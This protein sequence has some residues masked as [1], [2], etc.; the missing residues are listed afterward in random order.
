MPRPG[1][2]NFCVQYYRQPTPLPAEWEDDLRHVRDLGFTAVQLRPQWAWHEPREGEFRWDDIDRLMDL[3]GELGL[4]VL[5]K[6]FVESAPPW[7]FRNYES[8]RYAQDGRPI[9]PRA[10]GSFY[11]GGWL[12]CFDRPLVRE[13][14]ERFVTAG[15]LRY[16]DRDNLLGWHVWNEPRSRPFEDCACA[17]SNALYRRWLA[18]NF[19]SPESFSARFGTVCTDWEE[20]D[21]PPDSSAYYDTWLWRQYRAWAVSDRI[22]WLAGLVRSLDGSR[23][24]FCHVGF[25]SV[26]QPTLLDTCDDFQTAAHVDVYGT[27]FPHWT[28]D[29]HTFARVDRPSLFSN[30]EYRREMFLYSLQAR[31]MAAVKDYF[32]INEVY[33]NSWNYMAEDFSGEDIRF[34]LV[35]AISEGAKGIV[36]WQFRPER[37]SEESI[38]SGLIAPDGSDTER[39][40]A[41]AVVCAARHRHPEAFSTWTPEKSRV[42]LVFGLSLDMYSE[43]EDAEDLGRAGTVCYRY[44]DSL[45][46]W[47]SLFWQ[48]GLAVDIIPA[49]DLARVKDYDLVTLPY[50]HLCSK[51]QAEVIA[52]YVDGG[53]VLLAE[54]GTAFRDSH[55]TWV[56]PVRPGFGLDRLFGCREMSN[57][58]CLSP[59]RVEALGHRLDATRM[60]ARLDPLEG[61]RDLSD[62]RGFLFEK[63]AGNGRTFYFGFYPGISWRDTGEQRFLALAAD[64]L[65]RCGL[66]ADIQPGKPLVRVRRGTVGENPARPAAFVLNYEDS[67]QPVSV[68]LLEPGRYRCLLTGREIEVPGEFSVGP[69]ETLFLV[70]VDF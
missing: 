39:S 45:K 15:I 49:E 4:K 19:G 5:F 44:K 70:P 47:Y 22:R 10:R 36:I 54:P 3:T 43:I 25:N 53:G 55:T 58:A 32:W 28:G 30:P 51:E 65:K 31:W 66:Y 52:K 16:R 33:G 64:L 40:R 60:I 35:S 13:K 27:S 18:D 34:M 6:F 11:V 21:P 69:R 7:L 41:A 37:F 14:T 12:P 59:V 67:G 62:G 23:P 48:L 1:E 24:V 9:Q 20:L 68:R 2:F 29:F 38:T 42:A 8:K 46:G 17:D 56:N 50:F 26:L 61:A 63:S 57:K